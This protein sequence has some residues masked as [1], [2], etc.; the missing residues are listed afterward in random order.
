MKP[1]PTAIDL[2][3][4]VRRYKM[5]GGGC[6]ISLLNAAEMAPEV[7][8][9]IAPIMEAEPLAWDPPRPGSTNPALTVS[10]TYDLRIDG[11]YL[12]VWDAPRPSTYPDDAKRHD[13]EAQERAGALLL[14]MAGM[15]PKRRSGRKAA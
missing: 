2:V 12:Q 1:D 9:C 15:G 11:I 4:L 10:A 5:L 3:A 14:D 13:Y 7:L 6:T 8:A